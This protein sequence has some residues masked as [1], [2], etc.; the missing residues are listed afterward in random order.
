MSCQERELA[1]LRYYKYADGQ[2]LLLSPNDPGPSRTGDIIPPYQG[3]L[4]WKAASAA[5]Y[6][7]QVC[8]SPSAEPDSAIGMVCRELG[9]SGAPGTFKVR[10]P[11]DF[12]YQY[13]QGMGLTL[14]MGATN[15]PLGCASND[16]SIGD[17]TLDSAYSA[18]GNR[19]A[20]AVQCA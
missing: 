2:A 6:H 20:Y 3:L 15:M 8:S 19:A 14:G 18:C 16:S 17:C 7:L 11:Y 10:S 9:F 4:V 5:A 12:R 13:T 1:L